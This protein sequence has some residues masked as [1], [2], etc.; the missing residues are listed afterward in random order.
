MVKHRNGE[1]GQRGLQDAR[2]PLRRH[3][4]GDDTSGGGASCLPLTGKAAEALH[5]TRVEA[6]AVLCEVAHWDTGAHAQ[7]QV[8]GGQAQ[9]N[10]KVVAYHTWRVGAL[11]ICDSIVYVIHGK[12]CTPGMPFC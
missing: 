5:G 10:I 12:Y 4:Y 7:A 11:L 2:L 3:D 8:Q 9:L 1:D 6:A